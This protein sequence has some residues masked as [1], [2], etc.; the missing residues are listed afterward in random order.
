[1]DLTLTVYKVYAYAQITFII[2]NKY[3]LTAKINSISL[4]NSPDWFKQKSLT[5]SLLLSQDA[6]Q[7]SVDDNVA[8][9]YISD[10]E[11]T[12]RILARAMADE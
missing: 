2:V 10:V 6:I 8:G 3:Q 7:N 11:Q 1:M 12:H 9:I 4:N 5:G